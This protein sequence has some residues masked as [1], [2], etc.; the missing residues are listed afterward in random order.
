MAT[1][2]G[3]GRTWTGYSQCHC[4]ICHAV[5]TGVS[6]FDRHRPSYSGCGD[7]ETM[8]DTQGRPVFQAITNRLGVTWGR[9]DHS[10]RSRVPAERAEQ[11][12]AELAEETPA[13]RGGEEIES[14]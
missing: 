5:F 2:T 10:G 12:A 3:C 8:V 14:S 7:P 1:C 6:S 9:A 4:G 13:W 11:D